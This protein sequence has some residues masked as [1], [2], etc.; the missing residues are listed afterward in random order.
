LAESD[1]LAR[2]GGDELAVVLIDADLTHATRVAKR[3]SA[4]LHEPFTLEMVSVQIGGSIG[5]ALAPEHATDSATLMHRADQAMYRAKQTDRPYEI[6]DRTLDDETDRLRLVDEL[7]AALEANEFELH[8]QPQVDLTTG[9]ASTV[10]A[11]LRW[12]HPR[13]GFVPPLDFL[14]LA[15]EAGLMRALTTFVLDQSLARCAQWRAEG[16]DLSIAVNISATNVQD[17]GLTDLVREM[18]KRH[19]LPAGV[20]VLEIT[21]TTLISDFDRSA[22][23]IQQLRDLGCVISIDDFGAGF[24]SL[25][26]LS[27]LAVSELKLD[28]SFLDTALRDATDYTLVRATVEL[29]HSLQLEV[30]AE[31]VEDETTLEALARLG[32]DRAQG[33]HIARPAPAA[34]LTLQAAQLSLSARDI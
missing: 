2:I 1:L 4:A 28:R 7:R 31:G 19:D 10:E 11:L 29:A 18:L 26:Y 8:Y 33:F 3:I 23:V 25:A 14:P 5:I 34:E 16:H 30:V 24:T 20:L 9:A 17:T 12:P 15:E 6:Y 22:R 27:R 32:C 21:E 13:L